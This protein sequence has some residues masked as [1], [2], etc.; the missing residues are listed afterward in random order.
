MNSSKE[1]AGVFDSG[2]LE[3]RLIAGARTAAT[4][5]RSFPGIRFPQNAR[6]A[7]SSSRRTTLPGGSA[8]TGRTAASDRGIEARQSGQAKDIGM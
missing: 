5:L 2:S 3:L 7:G 1:R 6:S 8:P 4:A